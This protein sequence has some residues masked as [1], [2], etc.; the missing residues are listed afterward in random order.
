MGI[1]EKIYIRKGVI[2]ILIESRQPHQERKRGFQE[3]RSFEIRSNPSFMLILAESDMELLNQMP[4]YLILKLFHQ[5]L[6]E[7]K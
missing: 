2:I 5:N 1:I 6:I 7:S 3:E 4:K